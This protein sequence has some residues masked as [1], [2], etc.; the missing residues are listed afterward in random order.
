MRGAVLA[1]VLW[2]L[3]APLGAQVAPEDFAR[4]ADVQAEG[5]S[6]FRLLLPDDVYETV[7]R[8][9]VGDLRVL[10]AAGDVV[11]HALR[12]ATAP[13]AADTDWRTVPSFPMTDARTGTSG[14]TQ[15]KVDASGAVLEVTSD[16]VRQATSAYLVDVSAIDEP[17]ARLGLSWN[18]PAGVTFLARVTVQGSNDLNAWRT[19]VSSA[20]VAQL[21][22][23]AFA[24]TQD[25]IALPDDGERLRYLRISWPR[26]LTAVTL[27]SVRV[28]PRAAAMPREPRWRTLTAD[29]VEGPGTAIYDAR[30]L[31]PIE[32]LDMDFVDAADAVSAT[33]R[34]RPTPS[35]A[36]QPRH[37]GLFY[38]LREANGDIRSAPARVGRVADRYWSVERAGG[39]GW[40]AAQAP[41]LRLG[42]HPHELV[43]VAQGSP[44]FTLVYGSARTTAADAPLDTLLQ[45][46]DDADRGREVRSATLGP[47]RTLGGVAALT[48]PPPLRRAVLWAVLAAAVALLAWLAVRTLRD[49]A[50]TKADG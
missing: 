45:R 37:S 31:F 9:D 1:L 7:T 5:G 2:L 50:T 20:A 39:A 15:V 25:E 48:P 17:L 10:N 42:W 44:P 22:R 29:R 41:R 11:P 4:G 49:T 40:T 33:V 21:E 14:R 24:L 30:G 47:P 3:P 36:W 8:P 16:R 26:E 18:A 38:S 43:F 32:Y 12:Q 13:D 19:I 34:S 6:L 46:L 23:D 35:A 27:T 28:R